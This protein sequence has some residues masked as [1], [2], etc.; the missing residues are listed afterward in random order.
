MFRRKRFQGVG[1]VN[2]TVESTGA[3]LG[4]ERIQINQTPT[5]NVDDC[6][7]IAQ[8]RQVLAVEEPPGFVGQRRRQYQDPG[9]RKHRLQTRQLYR[10][11][12]CQRSNRVGIINP[13]AQIEAAQQVNDGS[14]DPAKS[15]HAKLTAQERL[16]RPVLVDDVVDL[17]SWSTQLCTIPIHVASAIKDQSCPKFGGSECHRLGRGR[18]GQP[19]EKRALKSPLHFTPAMSN[20]P[21]VWRDVEKFVAEM[22]TVPGGD[23]SLG[24]PELPFQHRIDRSCPVSL[25]AKASRKPVPVRGGEKRGKKRLRCRNGQLWLHGCCEILAYI[26]FSVVYLFL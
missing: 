18:D 7:P 16:R 4:G 14:A 2:R 8:P 20:D 25:P 21:K 11:I 24:S 5:C 6:A 1:N 10:V 3:H 19:I 12:R 23:Q 26:S 13:P 22:R 17:I 9:T 15:D